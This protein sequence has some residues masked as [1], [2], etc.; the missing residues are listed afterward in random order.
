MKLWKH[1]RNA[2]RML[3]TEENSEAFML[4]YGSS[5]SSTLYSLR[6]ELEN[7]T[8]PARNLTYL[9]Y[10]LRCQSHNL[11][12]HHTTCPSFP[13]QKARRPSCPPNSHLLCRH[14]CAE[15]RHFAPGSRPTAALP[16]RAPLTSAKEQRHV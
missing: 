7:M 15:A 2:S 9:R 12:F 6:K 14:H 13:D 4:I 16:M 1:S 3:T 5:T 11:L 8:L 10:N